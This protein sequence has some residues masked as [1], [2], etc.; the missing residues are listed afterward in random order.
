MRS[1]WIEIKPNNYYKN[2]Y[3]YIYKI[4]ACEQPRVILLHLV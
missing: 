2:M 1:E 3:I 4:D